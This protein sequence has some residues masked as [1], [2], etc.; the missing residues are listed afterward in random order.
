LA[1]A[2][3]VLALS[4]SLRGNPHRAENRLRLLRNEGVVRSGT[5]SK[6]TALITQQVYKQIQTF[7][8]FL[9]LLVLTYSGPAKSMPVEVNGGSL[10]TQNLGR[11]GGKGAE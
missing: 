1:A 4:D 11:G 7:L 6:C 5:R 10:V 9:G 2:L 3:K 8:L